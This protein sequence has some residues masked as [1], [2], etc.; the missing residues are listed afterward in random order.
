[1][2]EMHQ[3]DLHGQ[4]VVQDADCG[5]FGT[6]EWRYSMVFSGSKVLLTQTGEWLARSIHRCRPTCDR[7]VWHQGVKGLRHSQLLD[8]AGDDAPHSLIALI[9]GMILPAD[10]VAYPADPRQPDF[11]YLPGLK[12][13]VEAVRGSDGDEGRGRSNESRADETAA[14]SKKRKRAAETSAGAAAVLEDEA[15]VVRLCSPGVVGGGLTRSFQTLR[16]PTPESSAPSTST[17]GVVLSP[18]RG[19]LLVA[20][21][22]DG[23]YHH[24]LGA[25]LRTRRKDKNPSIC[26]DLLHSIASG[27][28][29]AVWKGVVRGPGG[30]AVVTKRFDRARFEEMHSELRALVAVASLGPRV[31]RCTAVIAPDDVHWIVIVME[32][33][34]SQLGTWED[35]NTAPL[36]D[37]DRTLC[38]MHEL[39][40]THGDVEPRNIVRRPSG[41]LA[42]VDFGRASQDHFCPGSSCVE[43]QDLPAL[44]LP[45]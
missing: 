12:A 9:I 14:G 19:L 24:E 23:I 29:E 40:V 8:V 27:Y 35:W 5:V 13:A 34:G 39:G 4:S 17:S 3:L 6:P 31:A 15:E 38:Q 18:L 7:A 10:I 41:E 36:T 20:A 21:V 1:M 37:E 22:L 44:A 33:A 16:Y 28:K 25:L 30:G 42:C 11:E 43:L 45:P 2:I 32:D 26:I